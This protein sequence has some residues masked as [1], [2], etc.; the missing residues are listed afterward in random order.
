MRI[1]AR[2]CT[3]LFVVC[4]LLV[5]CNNDDSTESSSAAET[6][7]STESAVAVTPLLEDWEKPAVA[8]LLTGEQ[9]GYLEPCGCSETQSGGVARRHDLLKQ[10]IK[11]DWAVTGLDLGGTL[12]RSRL[13]SKIKF[14]AVLRALREMNYAGLNLGAGGTSAG[15]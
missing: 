6:D 14:D 15:C 8:F 11:R 2:H 7:A 4:S 3:M 1:I 9:H 10:M 12:K 5:G 13:Q